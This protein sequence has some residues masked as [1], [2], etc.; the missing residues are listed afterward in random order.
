MIVLIVSEGVL[1][2]VVVIGNIVLLFV[3]ILFIW[4]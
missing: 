1:V 3:V 4:E 2:K